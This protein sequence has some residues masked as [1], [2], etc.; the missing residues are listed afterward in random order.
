MPWQAGQT[1][2]PSNL[3]SDGLE[4]RIAAAEA[5]QSRL[6]V[7]IDKSV[8][9]LAREVA[10][11]KK[12]EMQQQKL[13]EEVQRD[14]MG[15]RER[16]RLHERL[17]PLRQVDLL[18]TLQHDLAGAA[19]LREAAPQRVEIAHQQADRFSPVVPFGA[20]KLHGEASPPEALPRPVPKVAIAAVAAAPQPSGRA[21][22][23]WKTLQLAKKAED[24]A[25]TAATAPQ[26]S[27]DEPKAAAIEGEGWLAGVFKFAKLLAHKEPAPAVIEEPPEP[28]MKKVP[29]CYLVFETSN[30]GSFYL[31]WNE[32]T[33]LLPGALAVF[34]PTK[35]VPRHK[36]IS[37][38]GRSELCRD[39]SG[40][41]KSK[42][43]FQGWVYFIK[44]ARSFGGSFTMLSNVKAKVRTAPVCAL[45]C[46]SALSACMRSPTAGS[47]LSQRRENQRQQAPDGQTLR[48]HR[49]RSCCGGCRTVDDARGAQHGAPS[50]PAGGRDG[51]SN[52]HHR[53][54]RG[55]Y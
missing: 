49:C 12:V 17:S 29:R 32:T 44:M 38:G 27:A 36:L 55:Q 16:M 34:E 53:P 48:V 20:V 22:A 3:T 14:G 18:K 15:K 41:G 28:T 10:R 11:L 30:A 52:T 54:R 42:R 40:P 19:M 47:H 45:A 9:Q 24:S 21:K 25:A 50:L 6:G 23:P 8:E 43:F 39:V 35:T 51:W 7:L 31:Q 1:D 33:E 37:G 2:D 13:Q 4:R 26:T 46:C 5:K